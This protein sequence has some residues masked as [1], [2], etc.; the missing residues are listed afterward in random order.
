MSR[1]LT[2]VCVYHVCLDYVPW[3]RVTHSCEPPW[4]CWELNP[5][6]KN[7]G[8]SEL[9]SHPTSLGTKSCNYNFLGNISK[10][11]EKAYLTMRLSS[12][13]SLK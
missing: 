12:E 2:Y 10:Y 3:T 11:M 7:N 1:C 4:E 8:C 6:L 13:H 5:A 9:P